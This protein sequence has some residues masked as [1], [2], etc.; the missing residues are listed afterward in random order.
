MLLAPVFILLAA[1]HGTGCGGTDDPGDVCGGAGE[2]CQACLPVSSDPVAGA[3]VG[4]CVDG[5]CTNHGCL[6]FSQGSCTDSYSAFPGGTFDWETERDACEEKDGV[7]GECPDENSM[8]DIEILDGNGAMVRHYYPGLYCSAAEARYYMTIGF[9]DPDHQPTEICRDD[10]LVCP[11]KPVQDEIGCSFGDYDPDRC[12]AMIG[13]IHQARKEVFAA[14][15]KELL[16]G[17]VVD[18]CPAGDLG[19]CVYAA[20]DTNPTPPHYRR[21]YYRPEDLE[22][23]QSQCDYP[24]SRWVPVPSQGE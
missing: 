5:V 10:G 3:Q 12:L 11:G 20:P 15:C 6:K 22:Y 19:S 18:E 17:E 23:A 7:W 8:L 16:D 9:E 1:V 2:P 13:G 4:E 21:F 24:G 14:Y